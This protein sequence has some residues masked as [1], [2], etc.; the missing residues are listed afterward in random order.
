VR[1]GK[2][3]EAEKRG[4]GETRRRGDGALGCESWAAS[5][6]SNH[7]SPQDLRLHCRQPWSP[8]GSA[9]LRDPHRNTSCALRCPCEHPVQNGPRVVCWPRHLPCRRCGQSHGPQPPACPAQT[10][11][12]RHS[13]GDRWKVCPLRERE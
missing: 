11:V 3:G 8:R 12:R 5:P 10:L 13:V 6:F 1:C 7:A 9:I 4:D 2:G